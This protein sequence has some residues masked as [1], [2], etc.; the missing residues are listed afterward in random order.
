MIA[1]VRLLVVVISLPDLIWDSIR[2]SITFF[3]LPFK[4]VLASET[5]FA[6]DYSIFGFR[7]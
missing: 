6:I 3:T 7:G 5:Y 2:E 4:N 1:G